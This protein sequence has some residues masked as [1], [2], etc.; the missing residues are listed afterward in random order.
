[1]LGDIALHRVDDEAR[2]EKV[3]CGQGARSFMSAAGAIKGTL[4][5]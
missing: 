4:P 1:M 2:G 3:E 5:V